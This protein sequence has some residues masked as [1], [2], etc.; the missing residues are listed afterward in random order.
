MKNNLKSHEWIKN[1]NTLNTSKLVVINIDT[2]QF[3][4]QIS[5]F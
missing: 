1:I 2:K 5:Q 3:Y 4:S